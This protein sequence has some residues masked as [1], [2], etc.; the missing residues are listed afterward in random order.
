M[1]WFHH[2]VARALKRRGLVLFFAAA[3]VVGAPAPSADA[4]VFYL[5][6]FSYHRQH[7]YRHYGY[8]HRRYGH[9]HYASHHRHGSSHASSSGGGGGKHLLGTTD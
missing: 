4:F 1:K 3:T 6:G 9:R 8:H 5:P 2:G 7:H